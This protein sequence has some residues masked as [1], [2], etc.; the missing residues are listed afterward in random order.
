MENEAPIMAQIERYLDGMMTKGDAI[1]FEQQ[2]RENQSLQ[3][4]LEEEQLVRA[5]M[6]RVREQELRANLKAWRKNA[7]EA[8]PSTKMRPKKRLNWQAWLALLAFCLLLF[9]V[10]RQLQA[11]GQGQPPI[12]ELN[13]EKTNLPDSNIQKVVPKDPEDK[14]LKV[15][16]ARPHEAQ[17]SPKKESEDALANTL[18]I[19]RQLVYDPSGYLKPP[20]TAQR[21]VSPA[22]T[23]TILSLKAQAAAALEKNDFKAA[24]RWLEKIDS[25]DLVTRQ[26]MAHALFGAG[27]YDEA[28]T[29]FRG[30]SQSGSFGLDARWNLAMC[31]FARYPKRQ[32]EYRME[33]EQMLHGNSPS[34]RDKAIK[35]QAKVKAKMP[36]MQ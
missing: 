22:D 25:S 18:A 7:P 35:W 2:L 19:V 5:A 16:N 21:S 32:E 30:L 11:A 1:A 3:A 28:A 14:E 4:A 9:W 23:L 24:L 29:V 31:Y 10:Y 20:R 13:R 17:K 12:D 34:L 26:M 27:R 15:I 36:G 8:P 33:M 6:Q